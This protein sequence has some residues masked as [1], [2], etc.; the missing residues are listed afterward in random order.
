MQK[1]VY[2][3]LDPNYGSCF[4]RGFQV[5]KKLKHLGYECKIITP[6]TANN[7][8]I[9]DSIIF[10]IKI[11]PNYVEEFHKSNFIIWDL[12]DYISCPKTLECFKQNSP[13][14]DLLI[15]FNEKTSKYIEE[16][17]DIT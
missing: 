15:Y 14:V 3:Y 1:V 5:C 12:V 6:Q 4:L 7:L 10:I 2:F 16:K 17:F 8:K 9:K 13:K 11:W